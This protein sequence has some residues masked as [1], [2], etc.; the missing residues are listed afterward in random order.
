MIPLKHNFNYLILD[1]HGGVDPGQRETGLYFLD[2]RVL[3][4]YHWS[5]KD[6]NCLKR[7]AEDGRTLVE[8]WSRS[9]DHRQ[10]LGIKRTLTMTATGMIDQLEISNTDQQDQGFDVALSLDSDFADMFE[11]RGQFADLDHRNQSS[12]RGT[13]DYKAHYEATDQVHFDVEVVIKGAQFHEALTIEPQQTRKLTVEVTTSSSLPQGTE[14][15]NVAQGW[16]GEPPTEPAA[17]QAFMQASRDLQ[18]LLLATP[19]GLNIAAG[20]PWFVTPFGRDSLITAWFLLKRFPDLAK[21]VLRFLGTH[22]GAKLDEYRDEQP[23]KILHEQ[24]YG[25]LSRTGR[26]P[27]HT[28]YGA[29]DSTPLYLLV[30]HD[31]VKQTGNTELITELQPYWQACL[32]WIEQFRDE[33]GL[34]VFRGNERALTVQSWKDSKDSLSY[35]DGR[36]GEGSLAVAE[37]QGYAFAAYQAASDFYQHLGDAVK[38]QEYRAAADAIQSQLH[39]LFWMPADDNFAIAIDA[40]SAQL[41]TNSS[42]AGHLLW[43]GVVLAEHAQK[44]IPRMFQQ[45]LWSGWG[46]RTLSTREVRYNPLSYHNGSVWPHDTALFAAGLRRYGDEEGFE[47]V[48]RALTDLA[49]SQDDKRLPELVGGYDRPS[50]PP[51]PYLDACRPQAWSAAAMIYLHS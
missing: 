11:I 19:E 22:Q 51:L 4:L 41:A 34:I 21:G 40:D 10:L 29:A 38:A 26:L 45:D 8:Y 32:N 14:A 13:H 9:V 30:L 7:Q 43:T 31:T 42:D 25:E 23:G 47:R 1:D 33:R 37:V 18:C 2:T 50:Y 39:S 6:F 36:L 44:L 48:S 5:L 24:R 15:L 3:S 17:H 16:L 28:Y 20:M 27:F 35:A 12:S 46:L 49:M